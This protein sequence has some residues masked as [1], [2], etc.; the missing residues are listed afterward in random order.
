M[1]YRIDVLHRK[2]GREVF[3]VSEFLNDSGT[4]TQNKFPGKVFK[5]REDAIKAAEE[6]NNG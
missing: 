3:M 2:N 6:V 4:W 1:K 5:T